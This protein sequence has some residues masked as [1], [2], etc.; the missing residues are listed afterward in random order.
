M[1]DPLLTCVCILVLL[2]VL[3]VWKIVHNQMYGETLSY[4]C[5]S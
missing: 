3:L 1:E 5:S 2:I 4:L